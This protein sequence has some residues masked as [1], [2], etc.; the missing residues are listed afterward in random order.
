M[1]LMVTGANGQ[2]GT[3]LQRSLSPLGDVIALDRQ[4]CDLSRPERLP[5]IVRAHRPDVIINAAAYTAV[6]KAEDEETLAA[7][8]NGTAVGVLA[9]E[10]HKAGALLVHYS[11]DYVFDGGKATPYSES[12]PP[13]PINAYGRSKLVGETAL[14]AA[15]GHHLILRTSWVY[16]ARGHNFLRTILRLAHERDELRIVDDQT[17]APT[18]ARDIADATAAIVRTA[19]DELAQGRFSSGKFN[20]TAGGA[21]TWFG[22]A[23]AILQEAKRAG[24]LTRLPRLVAISSKDHPTA[25]ARPKNSRLAGERIKERFGIA[26]PDWQQSVARCMKEMA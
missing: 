4:A 9:E 19:R 11:T 24:L 5:D 22:F 8:V 3:E 2:V 1:R 13:H 17:G 20:L 18:W 14:C 16:G 15:G 6:D 25:A 7:V 21:A 10:A 23:D 12:D 26:L